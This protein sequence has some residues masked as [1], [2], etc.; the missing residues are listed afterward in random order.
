[1]L[2]FNVPLNDYHYTHFTRVS[3][4]PM[5]HV[6]VHKNRFEFRKLTVIGKS[7]IAVCKISYMLINS[8]P[9]LEWVGNTSRHLRVLRDHSVRISNLTLLQYINQ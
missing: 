3:S 2:P 7:T 4:R 8:V 1:M 5:Y 6:L 9:R